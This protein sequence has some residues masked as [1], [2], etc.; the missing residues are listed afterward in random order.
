VNPRDEQ[1]LKRALSIARRGIGRVAPNPLV[2]SVVVRDETVVGEGYHR[3]Y[4]GPHAEVNALDAAGEAARGATL[5]VTLEPCCHEGKTPPCTR[6]ILES[7]VKTV[8]CGMV[9]PFPPV[10]GKGIALLRERGIAVRAGVL[11]EQCRKLNEAYIHRL[12]TGRPFV[13][14]KTAM[15]LDGKIAA[16]SG[17]SKWITS[18][19]S[20]QRVQRMR[21]EADGVLTGIGTVLADDPTLVPRMKK[22]KPRHLRIVLD[23]AAETPLDSNL[24]RSAGDSPL[25]IMTGPGADPGRRDAL[26]QAGAEVVD[27]PAYEDRIDLAAALSHLGRRPV[28]HILVEA[29]GRVVGS[30]LDGGF[31]DRLVAFVAPS[32]LPDP[33]ARAMAVIGHAL[34]LGDAIPLEIESVRRSGPD[35]MVTAK[36]N[37]ERRKK[38]PP[39]GL[40][41]W[42]YD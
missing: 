40:S 22:R 19:E 27:V 39:P 20:R 29:G 5:Y 15:T 21:F 7:G 14:V 11:E 6:R 41:R 17:E 13:T 16:R 4:G 33:E 36:P 10:R 30:L 28:N 24:V 8:V 37:T 25:I 18:E 2:G 38:E 23:P 42:G 32:L 1:F 3:R 12:E 9:D 35:I 34:A 31:V 26:G